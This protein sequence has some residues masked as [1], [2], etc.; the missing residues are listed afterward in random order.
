MF[1]ASL[2]FAVLNLADHGDALSP[3]LFSHGSRSSI[4]RSDLLKL[5]FDSPETGALGAMFY[6]RR[7]LNRKSSH[8]C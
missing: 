7:V 8:C 1:L 4:S 2:Y 3:D 6:Y 5:P